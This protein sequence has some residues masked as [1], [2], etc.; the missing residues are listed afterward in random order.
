MAHHQPGVVRAKLSHGN[1]RRPPTRG[2]DG[3]LARQQRTTTAPAAATSKATQPC[4][5]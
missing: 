4:A 3:V 5:R 1:E 2:S